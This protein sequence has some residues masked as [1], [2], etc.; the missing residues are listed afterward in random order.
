MEEKEGEV[1]L[2]VV[3]FSMPLTEDLACSPDMCT[4]WESNMQPFVY[5]A[6]SQST[7]PHKPGM[8]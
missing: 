8:C 1:H 6:G 4:D 5:Q 2:G 3:A 7:E